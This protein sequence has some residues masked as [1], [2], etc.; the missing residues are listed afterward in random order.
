MNNSSIPLIV[1][2]SYMIAEIYKVLLKRHKELYKLIPIL[3]SLFGGLLGILIY[4]TN[5]ELINASNIYS[6]LEIGIISGASATTT[7]QII[8]QIFLKE[9]KKYEWKDFKR[10]I[11]S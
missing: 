1:I 7:N 6:A 11:N 10:R 3:V 8:K 4:L 2:L 9:D 5:K